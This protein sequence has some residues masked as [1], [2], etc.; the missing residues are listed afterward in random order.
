MFPH[1]ISLFLLF[2]ITFLDTNSDEDEGHDYKYDEDEEVDE[3]E[4]VKEKK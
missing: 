4:F 1:F 2:K 3:F